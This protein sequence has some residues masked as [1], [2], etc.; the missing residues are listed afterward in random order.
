LVSN[1][2]DGEFWIHFNDFVK[3]FS[4]T[5]VNKYH[6]DFVYTC[7][8]FAQTPDSFI[9]AKI[10]V[11]ENNSRVYIGLHQKQIRFYNKIAGYA[12]QQ[13]RIILAKYDEL[14]R[15]Y[16]FIGSDASS[17]DKLW[18]EAVL[19]AGVYHLFGKVYWPYERQDN[20]SVVLS[21]YAKTKIDFEAIEPS[22]LSSNYLGEI[23]D[24]FCEKNAESIPLINGVK[25][26]HSISFNDTGFYIFNVENTLKEAV[27]V[28]LKTSIEG[29]HKCIEGPGV[30][31][32]L[33]GNSNYEIKINANPESCAS[34]IIELQAEPWDCCINGVDNIK[35]VKAVAQYASNSYEDKIKSQMQNPDTEYN[36]INSDCEYFEMEADDGLLV[37][38][39]NKGNNQYQFAITFELNDLIQDKATPKDFILTSKKPIYIHLQYAPGAAECSYSLSISFKKK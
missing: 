17:S 29:D 9:S 14:K 10:T 2:K 6:S 30:A 5:F 19:D 26:L 24:D 21:T 36:K 7:K 27:E 3:Y 12:P 16:T 15:E 33:T 38:F 1:Y 39:V 34:A 23:L 31:Y 22:M 13:G 35:C 4:Y 28:S 20:C 25:L 32:N 8:K 11:S 37:C 18:I